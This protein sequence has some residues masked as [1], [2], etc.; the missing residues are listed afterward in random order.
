MLVA[1]V[2]FSGYGPDYLD[3]KQGARILRLPD[4]LDAAGC[5]GWAYGQL[6]DT[7]TAGWYPPTFG[8]ARGRIFSML[9]SS[10]NQMFECFLLGRAHP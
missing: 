5:G 1:A 7:A 6:L 9:L 8:R 3:F 2:D 10:S 4:P